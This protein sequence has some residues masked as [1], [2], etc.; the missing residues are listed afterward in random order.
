V[1]RPRLARIH[2][3]LR[4]AFWMLCAL[5]PG[6]GAGGG[7]TVAVVSVGP[8]SRG[9]ASRAEATD[10]GATCALRVEPARP[11]RLPSE[12]ADRALVR[13]GGDTSPGPVVFGEYSGQREY[14]ADAADEWRPRAPSRDIRR[15]VWTAKRRVG[16]AYNAP[17]LRIADLRSDGPWRE[18]SGGDD[19]LAGIIAAFDAEREATWVLFSRDEPDG[20]TFSIVLAEVD[21]AARVTA[22]HVLFQESS[23]D[24]LLAARTR[25]GD[26]AIS[27]I[28]SQREEG[29]RTL[30]LARVDGRTREIVG[31]PAEVDVSPFY[32]GRFSEM[33]LAAD[34]SGVAVAW[35]DLAPKEG[36]EKGILALE[37]RLFRQRARSEPPQLEW[38][39]G[40][41]T[42]TW[43]VAG[44]AGGILPIGLQAVSVRGHAV[45]MWEATPSA[46]SGGLAIRTADGRAPPLTVPYT[47]EGWPLLRSAGP[48]QARILLMHRQDSA[49]EVVDVRCE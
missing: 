36:L 9:A 27:W 24:H 30:S 49:H 10:D 6:C 2:P 39:T 43:N 1:L 15:E 31:K 16:Q 47:D 22:S 25:E 8:A 37:L 28:R 42:A 5:V 14:V 48:G 17:V 45:F 40:L 7:P 34:G 23:L 11:L 33:A 13:D 12:L 46:T 26:L 3:L 29:K 20:K 19:R 41:L 32:L 4:G 38:K 44:S 18:V 21:A 35:A